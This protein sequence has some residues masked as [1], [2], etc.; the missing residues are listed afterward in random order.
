MICGMKSQVASQSDQND[1]KLAYSSDSSGK[2]LGD[3]I[4]GL[5]L[6]FNDFVSMIGPFLGPVIWLVLKQCSQE[7]RKKILDVL[8]PFRSGFKAV[9]ITQQTAEMGGAPLSNPMG[10]GIGA[11]IGIAAGAA[12]AAWIN[13]EIKRL[14]AKLRSQSQLNQQL[15]QLLLERIEQGKLEIPDNLSQC[16]LIEWLQ[17][18]SAVQSDNMREIR[19]KDF[20]NCNAEDARRLIALKLIAE[21]MTA[22]YTVDVA[23]TDLRLMEITK[24]LK[25]FNINWISLALNIILSVA[26]LFSHYQIAKHSTAGVLLEAS[27]SQLSGQLKLKEAQLEKL[28]NSPTQNTTLTASQKTE[29]INQ[30]NS[31]CMQTR[32]EL[33]KVKKE[34][35][36]HQQTDLTIRILGAAA[37]RGFQEGGKAFGLYAAVASA[38]AFILHFIPAPLMATLLLTHGLSA[39]C[40]PAFLTVWAITLAALTIAAIVFTSLAIVSGIQCAIERYSQ[41]KQELEAANPKPVQQQQ[42]QPS[43]PT[44]PSVLSS[45]RYRFLAKHC[46]S[47]PEPGIEMTTIRGR[48]MSPAPC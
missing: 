29:K 26:L 10:M 14:D 34:L 1:T 16:E 8:S 4:E 24:V 11:G 43:S 15:N 21:M 13:P 32:T 44:K 33:N 31:E 22:L 30:L 7:H 19:E 12:L 25:V 37:I 3:S 46:P 9:G 45:L 48:Q 42:P 40:L 28:K 2:L 18:Q 39:I 36:A 47:Q 17:D 5:D 23:N 41:K 27:H 38:L 20:M 35:T 6:N